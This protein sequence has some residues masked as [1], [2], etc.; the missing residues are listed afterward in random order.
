MT[1][2]LPTQS[3]TKMAVL[4]NPSGK[5]LYSYADVWNTDG[6]TDGS[7]I[8]VI[9]EK[10]SGE[11]DDGYQDDTDKGEGDMTDGA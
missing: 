8:R 3:S 2:V 10:G 1:T 6:S 4:L 9:T 5:S 7:T 11:G